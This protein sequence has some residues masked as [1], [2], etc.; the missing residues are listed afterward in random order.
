MARVLG[1]F[2][3]T[4]SSNPPTWNNGQKSVAATIAT[5]AEPKPFG[6]E[7]MQWRNSFLA[8]VPQKSPEKN[9]PSPGSPTISKVTDT[10]K[11]MKLSDEDN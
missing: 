2:K 9:T 4:A 11:L 3:A 10:I 7:F 6:F 8:Q 1:N 5:P